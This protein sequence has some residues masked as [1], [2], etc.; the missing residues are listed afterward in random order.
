MS[1]GAEVIP[2][3]LE[4]IDGSMRGKIENLSEWALKSLNVPQTLNQRVVG[5]SPT[6]PTNI[7][8]NLSDFSDSIP[9]NDCP[10]HRFKQIAAS[11]MSALDQS[12]VAMLIELRQL[13]L[14]KQTLR[15]DDGTS[16]LCQQRTS[17]PTA[18]GAS[19]IVTIS[20]SGDTF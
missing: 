8:N 9:T 6:A 15:V 5:S 3:R 2:T 14:Q 13:F 10:S 16:A 20:M 18:S 17:K 11:R 19:G 4:R 12:G 7:F 1:R